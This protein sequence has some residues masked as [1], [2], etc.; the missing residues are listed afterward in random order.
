[1]S[2]TFFY[3]IQNKLNRGEDLAKELEISC[4]E[5]IREDISSGKHADLFNASMN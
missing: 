1:M 5:I 2:M 4:N 3:F